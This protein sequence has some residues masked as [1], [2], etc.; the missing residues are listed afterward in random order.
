MSTKRKNL[1]K[2][3]RFEVFKR[4]GFACVYCGAKAPTAIL[5][6]D[7]VKPVVDGGGD[8][9]ENLVTACADCNNGKGAQPLDPASRLAVL[10]RIMVSDLQDDEKWVAVAMLSP[11]YEED[12]PIEGALAIV[13]RM[14]PVRGER[15]REIARD[16]GFAGWLSARGG[17][18]RVAWHH[19]PASRRAAASL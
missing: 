4:D 6:A 5:N 18:P 19:L 17:V 7:H 14:P 2:R 3:L 9:M 13:R 15:L 10:Y 11:S 1:P 8:T 16:G 12:Y